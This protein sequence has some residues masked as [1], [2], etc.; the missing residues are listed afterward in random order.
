MSGAGAGGNAIAGVMPPLRPG[1]PSRP[2]L[3]ALGYALVLLP[4]TIPPRTSDNVMSR[5]LEVEA[6]ATRG[7]LVVEETG[8]FQKTRPVDLVRFRGHF[9]S[10]KP[11]VL[12]ALASPIY[13]LLDRAGYRFAPSVAR[14]TVANLALTWSIV[15]LASALSVYWLRV[16]LQGVD[17]P[18]IASDLLALGLGFGTQVLTWAVSF[19]NHSVAAACILGSM[20]LTLRE[21]PGRRGLLDRLLA[22]LLAGLAATVDLPAG[23]LFLAGIGLIQWGRA[24]PFPWAYALGAAGPLALHAWLQSLV[25]GSPLP[26]EMYPEAFH[27]PGSYWLTD[28]GT[29][30]EY[31]TRAGFALEL[32]VGPAG[33]LTLTPALLFGLLGLGLTIARRGDPARPIALVVGGSLAVLVGYYA[34]GVRRT[35]FG[36]QSFGVRHLLAIT[37]AVYFF[38]A[39]ALAK[40]R[41]R[42]APALFVVLMGVGVFYAVEGVRDPWSRVE[43]REEEDPAIRAAQRF[44]A[45]PYSRARHKRATSPRPAPRPGARP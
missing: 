27:Y 36:G 26:V 41:G 30:R 1:R 29:F 39:V 9:Y 14:F 44:V 42:V 28:E 7:T 16:L 33:W 20:A 12:A 45:Y 10:D 43:E 4:L 11:P 13:A 17:L 23:C 19:N 37:P 32:L 15:G 21:H 18:P 31:G 3:L 2:A 22:G 35:D 5:Y 24:W 40:L 34:W 8:L 38:A 25:T 6:I